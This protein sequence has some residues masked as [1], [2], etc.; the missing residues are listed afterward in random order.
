MKKLNPTASKDDRCLLR[1]HLR[2]LNRRLGEAIA[3]D[4]TQEVA[5]WSALYSKEFL[6]P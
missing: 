1:K 4:L 2:P 3:N 6:E 5:E